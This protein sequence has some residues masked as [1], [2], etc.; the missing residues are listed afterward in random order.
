MES[1]SAKQVE[2]I[3]ADVQMAKITFTHLADDL[4][5]HICCEVETEMSS[6]KSFQDAYEKVRQLFGIRELQ[7]IQ[8]NTRYL[9]D[10]NYKNMK[11][12][13]KVSGTISLIMLGLATVFK[14]FHW[15]GA[16][17]GFVFGF[18]IL[19][20]FFF[21]SAIYINF[22]DSH[23][24]KNGLLH[25]TALIGGIAFMV[26]V[27]FKIMHWPGAGVMLVVGTGALLLLFMPILLFVSLK[28][29]KTSKDKMLYSMGV[30]ALIIFEMSFLFKMMHWPGS[31]VLILFG[32]IL[33][34]TVFLPMYT[35]KNFKENGRITGQYIF[36]V[37]TSMFAIIFTFLL[38]INVS[39]NVL[40]NFIRQDYITMEVV[41]HLE[42]RNEKVYT[43]YEKMSDSIHLQC[44]S[45]VAVLKKNT[46]DLYDFINELKIQ[47]VQATDK[48]D[49]KT[50]EE[51]IVNTSRIIAKDN[52][53][54]VHKIM[55]GDANN[56]KATML[57]EKI[58]QYKTSVLALT[59]SNP[60]IKFLIEK[61][62]NTEDYVTPEF[63]QTWEEYRFSGTVLIASLP[64]FSD[65]EMNVKQLEYEV[66]HSIICKSNNL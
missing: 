41:K 25:L 1:L 29:A 56:G 13:M 48:T 52:Y 17:P 27:L 47:L 26:G 46:Q 33:L 50:A 19:S 57:K 61:S 59:V 15:P 2:I 3:S 11:K 32:S 18:F 10:K 34:F 16:G 44:D 14:I 5:D 35:Y 66:L 23:Q 9:I 39:K 45:S 30:F 60:R 62:L 64:V 65:M 36:L 20:M 49:K 12:M 37:T 7:K 8:E 54:V 6:G 21:P 63:K 51:M 28:K 40:E 53:E 42:V 55:L 58:E 43:E 24:K 31:S 38:S 22:R 4:I